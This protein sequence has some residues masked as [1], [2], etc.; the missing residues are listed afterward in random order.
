MANEQNLR[1]CEY[2]FSQEEQK[3]GGIASGKARRE[4]KT[5]R[6]ITNLILSMGIGNGEIESADDVMN[7][8]ELQGK[9]IDVQTA[10]TIAM[11]KKA[12]QG[13][14]MASQYILDASGER[15]TNV[16]VGTDEDTELKIQVNYGKAD[17]S[18]GKGD[19]EP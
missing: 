19:K 4:K 13:S 11:V 2:K 16:N 1:P 9:N 10:I 18:K 12:M 6:E 15:E 5:I 7:I 8:A 14:I 17:K 3:R